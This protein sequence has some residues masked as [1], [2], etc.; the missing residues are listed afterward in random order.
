[1]GYLA[2]WEDYKCQCRAS[3][4]LVFSSEPVNLRISLCSHVRQAALES[5]VKRILPPEYWSTTTKT[6]IFLLICSG[7]MI[8]TTLL[9][10]NKNGLLPNKSTVKINVNVIVWFFCFL[11]VCFF[12][13]TLTKQHIVDA[14]CLFKKQNKGT[15]PKG[16][17]CYSLTFRFM[18]IWFNCVERE[19]TRYSCSVTTLPFTNGLSARNILDDRRSG[20]SQA[21]KS[22]FL[23][24]CERHF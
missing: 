13:F 23:T 16:N 24:P 11:F 5:T 1:M 18:N 22:S 10:S 2:L 12:L 9:M 7:R 17:S 3:L 8:C 21:C 14:F 20:S 6:A 19:K 15:I 4:H